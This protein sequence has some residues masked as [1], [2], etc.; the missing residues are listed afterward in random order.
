MKTNIT[1]L[2]HYD[3]LLHGG[4]CETLYVKRTSRNQLHKVVFCDCI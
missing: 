2:S 4:C 1:K 3:Y